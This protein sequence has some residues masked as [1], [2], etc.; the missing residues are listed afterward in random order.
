M[1]ALLVARRSAARCLSAYDGNWELT[2]K[3]LKSSA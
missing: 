3:R 2:E 1:E